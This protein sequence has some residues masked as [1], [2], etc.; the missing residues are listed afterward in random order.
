MKT[1]AISFLILISAGT[2]DATVIKGKAN[3]YTLPGRVPF[4]VLYN[5]SH[6]REA[7]SR[8]NNPWIDFT[9]YAKA[10][11]LTDGKLVLRADTIDYGGGATLKN[12]F[13]GDTV[14]LYSDTSFKHI[15]GYAWPAI[16][17]LGWIYFGYPFPLTSDKPDEHSDYLICHVYGGVDSSSILQF[18]PWRGVVNSIA[19]TGVLFKTSFSTLNRQMSVIDN[20]CTKISGKGSE[21]SETYNENDPDPNIVF[22]YFFRDGI[23]KAIWSDHKLHVNGGHRFHHGY[24]YWDDSVQPSSPKIERYF[25][26]RLDYTP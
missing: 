19:D 13:V 18:D 16:D 14:Y 21:Y 15:T 9:C 7:D 11:D 24:I 12:I 6:V 20:Y 23:L 26:R 10:S 2:L 17:S 3:V 25:K 5:G 4:A 1:S 22:L 8:W